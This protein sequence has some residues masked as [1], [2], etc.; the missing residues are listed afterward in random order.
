MQDVPSVVGRPIDGGYGVADDGV[1][2]GQ[3]H[4][5]LIIPG[6]TATSQQVL[7]KGEGTTT[8]RGDDL[9]AI[10]IDDRER[11]VLGNGFSEDRTEALLIGGDEGGS[12]GISIRIESASRGG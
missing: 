1:V 10:G 11:P 3:R 6:L 12:L 5:R 7:E 9:P 8:R 4:G 2:G